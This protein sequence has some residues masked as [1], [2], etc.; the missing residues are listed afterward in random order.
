MFGHTSG[1]ACGPEHLLTTF[2]GT[3]HWQ[4]STAGGTQDSIV[5]LWEND[6]KVNRAYRCTRVYI[7]VI[8]C[9]AGTD[10]DTRRRGHTEIGDRI[11]L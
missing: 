8:Y 10:S 2:A 6:D 5:A 4:D 11:G 9:R 3:T 7:R 1:R